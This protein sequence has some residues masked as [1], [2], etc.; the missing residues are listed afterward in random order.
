MFQYEFK[1][2]KGV[3][4][5]SNEW[6]LPNDSKSLK[7][8]DQLK[9]NEDKK[10]VNGVLNFLLESIQSGIHRFIKLLNTLWVSHLISR[11]SVMVQNIS[12]EEKPKLTIRTKMAEHFSPT[13]RKKTSSVNQ[14]IESF[15]M[16]VNLKIS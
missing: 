4:D 12:V 7:Q 3:E 1:K 5:L 10:E 15:F 14:R 16:L 13:L 9:K 11:I 8:L 6:I 2:I